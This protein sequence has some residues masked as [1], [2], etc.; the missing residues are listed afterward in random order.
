MD[1]F[2]ALSSPLLMTIRL[3]LLLGACGGGISPAAMKCVY[4]QHCI[5]SYIHC[6]VAPY[7]I[8][9]GSGCLPMVCESAKMRHFPRF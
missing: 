6:Y 8:M 4:V 7:I 2:L 9:C 5:Y 3:D 1:Y